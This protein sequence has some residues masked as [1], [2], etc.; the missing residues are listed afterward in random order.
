M[1]YSARIWSRYLCIF[2]TLTSLIVLDAIVVAMDM[3]IKKFGPTNMGKKRLC[4]LTNAIHPTKDPYEERKEDQVNTIASQMMANGMKMDCIIVRPKNSLDAD[5]RILEENDFL[6]SVFSNKSSTK[7]VY[8][9]SSTKL[10]GAIRTR[11]ISPVTSYRG[12]FE[13]SSKL[14][15]K[16]RNQKIIS[17]YEYIDFVLL[18]F[19]Y[20]IEKNLQSLAFRIRIL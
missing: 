3:M 10:L 7:T 13:L 4:L 1:L 20:R 6:L 8:V 16:V 17:D 12:Y 15:I 2:F 18:P 14:K 11:N 9:E 19:L 5:K